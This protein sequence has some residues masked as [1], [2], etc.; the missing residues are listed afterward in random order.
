[1]EAGIVSTTEYLGT[2]VP[3]ALG[4]NCCP[5][6]GG[7]EE[8]RSCD[9]PVAWERETMGESLLGWPDRDATRM[10]LCYMFR[11]SSSVALYAYPV[12]QQFDATF[13]RI[14]LAIASET[15]AETRDAALRNIG[16]GDVKRSRWLLGAR[17]FC[18]LD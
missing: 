4:K 15:S 7:V 14:T 3:D 9:P 11:R 13:D 17:L 10:F 18:R 12:G 16:L 6:G 2:K 8:R 1:M 5:P